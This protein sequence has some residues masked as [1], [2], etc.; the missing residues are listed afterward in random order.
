MTDAQGRDLGRVLGEFATVMAG[1]LDAADVLARLGDYCTELLPVK[2]VG[3]LLRA[4]DG[5]VI[6]TA[7]SEPGKTVEALEV[8]LH[9]GPCTE[10]VETGH[11]VLVPDL[12]AA[13]DRYPRFAPRA[14]EAGV[15]SIHALPMTV[16]TDTMGSVDVIALEPLDLTAEQL[17]T[18]QVLADVAISYIANSWAFQ[19]Q[20]RLTEQLQYALDSRIVIEQA[21]GVLAERHGLTV[22]DAFERMRRHARNNHVKLKD[23]AAKIVAGDLTI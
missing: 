22:S 9:E 3:V 11:Q 18:A 12:A 1:E 19:K 7:N 5:L 20:S 17:G 8:E 10:S 21:K 13:V 23:V 2:G 16:R 14:L 15:R 4:E 6:A